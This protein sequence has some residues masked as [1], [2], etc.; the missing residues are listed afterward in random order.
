MQPSSSSRIGLSSYSAHS[1][2]S[3]SNLRGTAA[4]SDFILRVLLAD[5]GDD[6]DNDDD[7]VKGR[8]VHLVPSERFE[9]GNDNDADNNGGGGAS[10]D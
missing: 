10:T 8:P 5:G 2:T 7:G 9:Q 4:A 3:I 1:T 6:D